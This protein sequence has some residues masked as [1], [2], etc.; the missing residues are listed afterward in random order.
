M[1]SFNEISRIVNQAIENLDW[2]ME[3]KGLYAP[4]E[5]IL[6]LGGKRIRPAMTLMA[7]ELFDGILEEA[8]A[9]ALGIEIFHNFT[10]LH[11]DI[12]DKAPIRRGKPTVHIKWNDNTA[13]LSGDV[14]QIAAYQF[15]AKCPPAKLPEVLSLFSTTAA[16]ICEGQ[17]YDMDF[18]N[19]MDVSEEEYL[20]MI[21]LKTAVLLGC[22]LKT[23]AVLAGASSE[24]SG[25]LYEFGI[26]LGLAFQLMD[27]LLDVYGDS[28][29]FGKQVG[30]DILANKKTFMLIKALEKAEGKLKDELNECLALKEFDPVV[31]VKQVTEIYNQLEIKAAC[32]E[33]MNEYYLKAT[34]NLEAVDIHWEKKKEL[35][36]LADTLMNRN[37]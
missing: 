32:E 29:T 3:P 6:S 26:N 30:G 16:E 34:K 17:Q 33:K 5:Y 15:I 22:S 28:K 9:P 14:M 10:L 8:L 7:A 31:K 19:R 18:E 2:S 20:N 27:D 37:S 12:M 25:N 21:R 13:I 11:D 4:I 23:G 1:R 35:T 24:N 36:I